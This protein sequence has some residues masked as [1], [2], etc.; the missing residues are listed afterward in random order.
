MNTPATDGTVNQALNWLRGIINWPSSG[1]K[2]FSTFLVYL[3]LNWA[4]LLMLF[5]AFFVVL[6]LIKKIV[7]WIIGLLKG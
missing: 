2:D 3:K 7:N 4:R 6:W 5:V 1:V